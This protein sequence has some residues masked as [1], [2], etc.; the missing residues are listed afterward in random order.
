MTTVGIPALNLWDYLLAIAVTAMAVP[1]A[2]LHHPR[3]KAWIM[4]L[5]IPFTIA[6]LAVGQPVN[7]THVNGL[8]VLLGY[9]QAAR[10]LYQRLHVPIVPAIAIAAAGYCIAAA[11]LAIVIPKTAVAFWLACCLVLLTALLSM[12]LLP[13]QKEQGHRTQMPVWLKTPL[14]AGVVIVLVLLKETLQGFMTF[15]PMVGVFAAYEAR[16][17]LWTMNRQVPVI[18][19]LTLPMLIA[20]YFAQTYTGLSLALVIGWCVMLPLFLWRLNGMRS[21]FPDSKRIDFQ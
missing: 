7:A 16:N 12:R 3:W 20:T 5:P 14:V 10:L 9:W 18:I 8:L 15:F 11:M 21:S 6:T 4:T 13:Q 1:L 2:Y 17:C 19:F